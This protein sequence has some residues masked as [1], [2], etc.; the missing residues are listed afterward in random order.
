VAHACN[1]NQSGGKDQEDHGSKP[2]GQIDPISKI[3]IK[4]RAWWV[5]QVEHTINSFI[6]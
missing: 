1:P 6:F 4:K 2:P 5:A 3:S